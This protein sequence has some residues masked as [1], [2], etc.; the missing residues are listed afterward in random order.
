VKCFACHK[1]GHYASQYPNKKK[2]KSQSQQT[3][4]FAK[5]QVKEFAKKFEEFLLVSCLFGTDS[6]S[7]WFV[8]SGAS[9]LI[10]WQGHICCSPVGQ[11]RT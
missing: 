7:A 10:T 3:A 4:A 1:S 8:D 2:G 5:A 11:R 9:R 6:D